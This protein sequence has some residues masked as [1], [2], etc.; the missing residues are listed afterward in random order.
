MGAGH[1]VRSLRWWLSGQTY[2]SRKN[3][4]SNR[5]KILNI[6]GN[7]NASVTHKT[8]RLTVLKDVR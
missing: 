6:I 1:N 2:N 3:K 5:Y 7:A 8:T 4:N